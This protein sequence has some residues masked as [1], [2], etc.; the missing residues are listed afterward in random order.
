MK[1]L[2]VVA[3]MDDDDAMEL[4]LRQSLSE[5]DNLVHVLDIPAENGIS[6][7]EIRIL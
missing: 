1:V 2:I 7:T 6:S 4:S 3:D 5:V